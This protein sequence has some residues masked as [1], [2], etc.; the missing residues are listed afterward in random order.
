MVRK[1]N[2]KGIKLKPRGRAFAPGNNRGKL[3]NNVLASPGHQI[4]DG[5]DIIANDSQQSIL[6]PKESHLEPIVLDES[7]FTYDK[8]ERNIDKLLNENS[9]IAVPEPK[10]IDSIEFTQGVNKLRITLSKK[11]NRMFRVQIFLNDVTE[12]RPV[13]YTGSSP[14]MTFWQLLKGSLK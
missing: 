3:K 9:K 8:G 5:G 2:S 12:V 1:I 4:G 11:H 7:A 6:D 14:A 10:V 13:T